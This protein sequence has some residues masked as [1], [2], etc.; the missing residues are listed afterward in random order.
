MLKYL[1][2]YLRVKFKEKGAARE[3][4]MSTTRG[5]RWQRERYTQVPQFTTICDREIRVHDWLDL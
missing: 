4:A 1:R 3:N 2:E 5:L